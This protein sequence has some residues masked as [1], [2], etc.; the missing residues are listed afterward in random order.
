MTNVVIKSANSADCLAECLVNIVIWPFLNEITFYGYF[1]ADL[2]ML[3][4]VMT[5]YGSMKIN[6]VIKI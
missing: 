6:S 2:H 3:T 1:Y 5:L 4:R